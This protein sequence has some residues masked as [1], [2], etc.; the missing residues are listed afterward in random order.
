MRLEEGLKNL[1]RPSLQFGRVDLGRMKERNG[2][3]CD[4]NALAQCPRD[5]PEA[6]GRLGPVGAV[7]HQEGAGL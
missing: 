1:G 3:H 6:E 4:T 2:M 5:S 7:V